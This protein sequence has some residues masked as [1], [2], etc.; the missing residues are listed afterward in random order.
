[1]KKNSNSK[2]KIIAATSMSIFS[3]ASVFV[4]CFAWFTVARNVDTNGSG[5]EVVSYDGLIENISLYK[6]KDYSTTD[7]TYTYTYEDKIVNIDVD[8]KGSLSYTKPSETDKLMDAYDGYFYQTPISVLALIKVN[9][10]VAKTHTEGIQI[11]PVS[12]KTSEQLKNSAETLKT[13]DN[14]LSDI[15]QFSYV[16]VSKD[17]KTSFSTSDFVESNNSRKLESFMTT[18]ESSTGTTAN[19]NP[20][21]SGNKYEYDTYK[22]QTNDSFYIGCIFEYSQTNIEHIYSINI[23]NDEI[24]TLNIGDSL[25]YTQ[26]FYFRI[27]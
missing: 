8:Q 10:T 4:A 25:T 23:A 24:N 9:T 20:T 1:M 17:T 2:L 18:S 14:S 13:K 21:L 19:Y 5:F 12:N 15:L 26:D 22:D 16:N 11:T 6:Q 27:A 3:L 7:D